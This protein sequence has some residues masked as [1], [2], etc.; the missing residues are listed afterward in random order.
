M[1]C[2][3]V[4]PLLDKSLELSEVRIVAGG[5]MSLPCGVGLGNPPGTVTWL[6]D[7]SVINASV[8]ADGRLELEQVSVSAAGAY[9]CVVTNALGNASRVFR[10][11]VLGKFVTGS[12][13]RQITLGR[14]VNDYWVKRKHRNC[15]NSL[16][17]P[18]MFSHGGTTLHLELQVLLQSGISRIRREKIKITIFKLLL[19]RDP[20]CCGKWT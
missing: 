19:F 3:T 7:G 6:R 10:L 2:V 9:T 12:K 15:L 16:N 4:K 17:Y 20:S 18:H 1:L 14:H 11:N 5:M 13:C 8:L